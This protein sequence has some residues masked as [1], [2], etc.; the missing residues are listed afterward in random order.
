MLREDRALLEA[1]R[2]GDAHALE[3]VYW[4]YVDT[5]TDVVRRGVVL[6]RGGQV[7]GVPAHEVADL[8]QDTFVR[9]FAPRARTAYDG[10]RDYR[11]YLLTICRNLL[12]DWARKQGRE[13]PEDHSLEEPASPNGEPEPWADPAIMAIV[14]AYVATL[15]PPLSEVYE[16][17]FRQGKSQAAAAGAL[18]LGRQRLRTFEKQIRQGLFAS[19]SQKGVV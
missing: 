15:E 6:S 10:L 9:A 18:K 2:A 5:I 19:L 8:V 17:R 12:V 3:K 4:H 7:S 1:F 14:D 11:P 16:Q 13:I